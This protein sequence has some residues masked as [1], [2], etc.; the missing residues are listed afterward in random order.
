MKQLNKNKTS[1]KKPIYLLDCK[2]KWK[3]FK[4]LQDK[5]IKRSGIYPTRLDKILWELLKEKK[6]YCWFDPEIK[7]DMGLGLSIPKGR[8]VKLITNVK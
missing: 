8:K 6:I 2:I 7:N 4:L 5:C 1:K 3:T